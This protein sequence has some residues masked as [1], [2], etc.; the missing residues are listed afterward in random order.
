MGIELS[1]LRLEGFTALPATC[2]VGLK[3]G[4][5]VDPLELAL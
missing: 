1:C 5:P 3:P 2:T 4:R